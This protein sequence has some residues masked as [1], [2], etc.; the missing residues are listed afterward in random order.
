MPLL[1]MVSGYVYY[2]AY[3]NNEG[4][5][6]REKICRQVVNMCYVYVLFSSAYGI[7]K[8]VFSK[9]V[10]SEI[11]FLS[12]VQIPLKPISLYW[13]M[14]ILILLYLLFSI[15]I[16]ERM[17]EKKLLISTFA[18]SILGQLSNISLFDC[19][20]LMNYIFYFYVGLAYRKYKGWFFKEKIYIV[21]MLLLS[22][23]LT[24]TLWD[25]A[26][27]RAIYIHEI[28]VIGIF[29]ALGIS[30][31]I[32]NAFEAIHPLSGSKLLTFLGRHSL[33]I[34]VL[35]GFLVSGLRI[36]FDMVRPGNVYLS[37]C[38]DLSISIFLPILFAEICKHL[39][40]YDLFFKPTNYIVSFRK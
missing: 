35:H 1:M 33:E 23:I 32:W 8:I 13:Y 2:M 5:P 22:I 14:Y 36:L 34:Y 9:R 25:A 15:T 28:P 3:Y 16:V 27:E 4:I 6:K 26:K 11:S 21:P 19:S 18:I 17:A 24:S 37:I 7:T 31:A 38:I 30:L 10:T 20:R 12:I 39:K 40:I 29:V